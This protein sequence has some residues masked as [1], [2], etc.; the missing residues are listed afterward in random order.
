MKWPNRM[1]SWI[2][3]VVDK[4]QRKYRKGKKKIL[5]LIQRLADNKRFNEMAKIK[6]DREYRLELYKEYYIG[7]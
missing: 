7:E 3:D 1:E 5:I 6:A 4:S 2:Y